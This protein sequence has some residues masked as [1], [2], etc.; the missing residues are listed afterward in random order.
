MQPTCVDRRKQPPSCQPAS[1]VS[2]KRGG[3]LHSVHASVL[4]IIVHAKPSSWR[5]Q[6]AWEA[7]RPSTA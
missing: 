4:S 7:R 6:R 3:A 5:K 2:V 1:P